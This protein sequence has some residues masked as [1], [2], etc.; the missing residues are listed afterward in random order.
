MRIR[1]KKA[2]KKRKKTSGLV[3][4]EREIEKASRACNAMFTKDSDRDGVVD[5]LDCQPY[6][7]K[8][9]G[10]LHWLE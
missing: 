6:N 9:Q 7:P 10:L 4:V 2:M 1:E 3:D 8:E 5:V